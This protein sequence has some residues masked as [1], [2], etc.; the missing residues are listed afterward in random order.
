MVFCLTQGR[1]NEL[2]SGEAQ[3]IFPFIYPR[4]LKFICS[5]SSEFRWSSCFTCSAAPVSSHSK[6][7]KIS[8]LWQFLKLILY[9]FS[10]TFFEN[11]SP[12]CNSNDEEHLN[13]I[14]DQPDL[15]D[16]DHMNGLQLWTANLV[17]LKFESLDFLHSILI[18]FNKT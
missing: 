17:H 2:F 11:S 8:F 7:W 4:C 3:K 12:H 10:C 1:R 15:D 14:L 6:R 18:F 5:K 13:H 16:V 9:L